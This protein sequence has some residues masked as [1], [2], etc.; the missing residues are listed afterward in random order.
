M[1]EKMTWPE[2]LM[3]L[4][5]QAVENFPADID[6]AV[7]WLWDK[8]RDHP[9]YLNWIESFIKSNLRSLHILDRHHVNTTIKRNMASSYNNDPRVSYGQMTNSLMARYQEVLSLRW[10]GEVFGDMIIGPD[11]D[12]LADSHEATANGHLFNAAFIRWCR[13]NGREGQ[14]V[15]S[16]PMKKFMAN[17]ER[18]QRQYGI[19]MPREETPVG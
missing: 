7:G 13:A 16:I 4:R 17:Y 5:H 3:E 11:L 8:V 19:K 12:E 9:D 6:A 2:W 14:P 15:S 10:G 18:L 1:S